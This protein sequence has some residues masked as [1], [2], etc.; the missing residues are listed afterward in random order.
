[1]IPERAGGL[2][3]GGQKGL[4]RLGEALPV[5]SFV[6]VGLASCI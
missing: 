5:V 6:G 3:E 2:K 4:M 1:M